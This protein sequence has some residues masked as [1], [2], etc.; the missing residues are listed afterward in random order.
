[1]SAKRT[2]EPLSVASVKAKEKEVRIVLS[3]GDKYSLTVDSF[4]DL[5]LYVGKILTDEEIAALKG[6]AD[7]DEAYDKA[8][9]YLSHESYSCAEIRRKLDAKGFEPE[10]IR[11]VVERLVQIG[12]LDDA[13]YART[14]AMDVADLRLLGRGRIQFE[15]RRKGISDEIIASL[16][17]PR[18]AE[19]DKA[20]RLGALLDRR[21][22]RTPY[23][24]RVLKMKE[25]LRS[26]GFDDEIAEEAAKQCAS[27]PD[28]SV[29]KDELEKAFNLA[30]A[31][32]SRKY[33]GY[34]L[35]QHILAALARKGFP[36][37]EVQS[38]LK[39][40]DL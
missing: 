3:N 6:Y 7:Q 37:D 28:P 32:Y 9:R 38:I 24:K 1:M 22:S 34:D 31:K 8:L 15:L 16:E 36:Y 30:Y 2:G 40:H 20:L 5:C 35:K 11:G 18:E 23:G 27:R 14:Y 10:V 4:T 21:Y 26:R 33:E 39:E 17:F 25:T 29:E 13:H 12:L 19:L